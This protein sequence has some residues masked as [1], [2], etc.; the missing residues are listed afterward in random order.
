M[1]VID[2]HAMALMASAKEGDVAALRTALSGADA[3]AVEC[4]AKACSASTV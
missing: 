4:A 1:V 2:S 3:N